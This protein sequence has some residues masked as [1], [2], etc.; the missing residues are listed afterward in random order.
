MRVWLGL[1][2]LPLL[3]AT[4]VNAQA[5]PRDLYLNHLPEMSRVV[6]QTRASAQL[7]LFGDRTG[8]MYC[9][10]NFDGIDDARAHRLHELAARFAPILRRNNASA[11]RDFQLAPDS[12]PWLQSDLWRGGK[13]IRTDS[14]RLGGPNRAARGTPT[15]DSALFDQKVLQLLRAFSPSVLDRRNVPAENDS[16]VV[17]FL[18]FPG[19]E[20]RS[21][22]RAYAKPH[23]VKAYVHPFINEADTPDDARYALVL[24]YWYFYPFNDGTNNHEGDWEHISVIVTSKRR[25]TAENHER[26]RQT[27]EEINQLLDPTTPLDSI[28]I[29]AVEYYFHETF[30][31]L[32]YVATRSADLVDPPS[33]GEFWHFH[34][35]HEPD[36]VNRAIRMR[37]ADPALATH[38][39]AYIGGNNRGP[40]ELMEFWPRFRGA[41][42][43]NAHGS[44]P[45]PGTWQ[46]VGPLGSTEKLSGRLVPTRQEVD[47]LLFTDA[48]F[49][50]FRGSDLQLLPDWERVSDLVLESEEARADWAWLL[51]PIRWGYPVTQSPGSGLVEHTDL[52]DI[53]PEGPPFQ[54]TWNRLGA[55]A[56]WRQYDPQVL[57]VLMVP[58]TPWARMQS[59]WGILNV[60]LMLVGFMP[61]WS[62]AITQILPWLTGPLQA[63]GLS[64]PHTFYPGDP[65]FRFTSAAAGVGFVTGGDRFANLL[66]SG[67]DKAARQAA[68]QG[69]GIGDLQAEAAQKLWINTFYGR[70]LSVENTF[71][72]TH[73]T[74][75]YDDERVSA[76]DAP[77]RNGSIRIRELTGGFRLN[78][79]QTNDDA[80]QAFVRGGYAWTWYRLSRVVFNGEPQDDY[81]GGYAP[82][83][84]PSRRWWPNT[85]YV[86]TGV[87]IFAPRS[88]WM[89]SRVGVGARMDATA[90]WHG[91]DTRSPGGSN[92]GWSHRA[93]YS[94]SLLI[95]W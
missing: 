60:P 27:A 14:M 76:G 24:Q 92:L 74:L 94:I 28:V 70:K 29:S 47:G 1:P 68:K 20:A 6:S 79:W 63:V 90:S 89:L 9:D 46:S 85:W 75:T 37:M 15:A 38:P 22:R 69:S 17:L 58:S 33:G 51:L 53:S 8:S 42:N 49:L 62:V 61:G 7:Q 43:R 67:T 73:G 44:Y 36:F 25:S 19:D 52:G 86:G 59:G 16:Q 72:Q 56:G 48:N 45:F 50:A 41:Y 71:T 21:W 65:Q 18:D 83:L 23:G 93:E 13:L 57:R 26:A 35:W 95:A 78:G 84:W 55:T 32:D 91:L 81:N 40:D 34:V 3:L 4:S 31:V 88:R 10:S 87:E 66:L 11:P 39:V 5:V 54:P 30:T 12:A 77:E 82:T 64:P 80:L 2:L